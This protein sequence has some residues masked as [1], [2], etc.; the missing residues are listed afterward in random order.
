LERSVDMRYAGQSYELTVGTPDEFH[1][2]HKRIYGYADR[3]RPVEMVTIRVKATKP[4]DRLRITARQKRKPVV[5]PALLAD[6]GS[7]T[8]VPAGWNA[9]T[10]KVGNLI[11]E[12]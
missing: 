4:V 3:S 5:G 8:Y 7:T 10:D 12:R 2:T 9:R 1:A 6:Y 11:L